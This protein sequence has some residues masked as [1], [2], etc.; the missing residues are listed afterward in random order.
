MR[1][2]SPLYQ[3]LNNNLIQLSIFHELLSLDES[4]APYFGRHTAKLFI[5]GKTIRFGYNIWGLY[6]NGGCTYHLNIYQGKEPTT[7][8][9]QEPLGKRVINTMVGII[10]E[11]SDVLNHEPYFDNFFCSYE[12]MCELVEKDVRATG[13]IRENRT[14]GAKQKLLESKEL[15]KKEL[16]DFDYCTDGKVFAAKWHDNSIV[17]GYSKQLG[18]SQSLAQSESLGKRR[19]KVGYTA[20][21][22]QFMQ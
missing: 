17:S 4:M 18:N 20:T 7:P 22:Y 10:T 12:L 11:N 14:G 19:Q 15:Q 21:S 5:R 16:G 3:I 13:T 8:A 2:I 6:G 1:K 9:Q